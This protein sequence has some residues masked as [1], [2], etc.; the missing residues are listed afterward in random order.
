MID[1]VD[2]VDVGE[3]E[4]TGEEETMRTPESS[5][6]HTEHE[7]RT[8]GDPSKPLVDAPTSTA[9]RVIDDPFRYRIDGG[10]VDQPETD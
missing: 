4:G 8:V 10:H 1:S 6:R 3:P 5:T 7:Q 9:E 2:S